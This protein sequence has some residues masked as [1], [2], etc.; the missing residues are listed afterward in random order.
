MRIAVRPGDHVATI[1]VAIDY[2]GSLL[3]RLLT[4]SA[5]VT[6]RH[7]SGGKLALE[8]MDRT[9]CHCMLLGFFL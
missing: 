7:P 3:H 5:S 9:G 8:L 1:S 6:F 2:L 4:M